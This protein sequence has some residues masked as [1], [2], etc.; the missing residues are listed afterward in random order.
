MEISSLSDVQASS[1]DRSGE[2][3]LSQMV[4]MRQ[5]VSSLLQKFGKSLESMEQRL[6]AM[7]TKVNVGGEGERADRGA[8]ERSGYDS[9]PDYVDKPEG[10]YTESPVDEGY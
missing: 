6:L 3:V 9:D 10:D 8:S 1:L 4:L 2:L 7:E 5:N